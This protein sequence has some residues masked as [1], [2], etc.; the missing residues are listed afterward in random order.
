MRTDDAERDDRPA[1]DRFD[2]HLPRPCRVRV[3]KGHGTAGKEL[4]P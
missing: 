1:L 4:I 2:T 3:G